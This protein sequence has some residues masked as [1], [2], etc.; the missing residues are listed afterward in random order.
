VPCLKMHLVEL[1]WVSGRWCTHIY[2]YIYT[3][4]YNAAVKLA[5]P[6]I[7]HLC[8]HLRHRPKDPA[9]QFSFLVVWARARACLGPG[10][11][12]LWSRPWPW[13]YGPGPGLWAHK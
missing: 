2:I 12:A 7:A 9:K 4:I 10:P 5:T 13:A 3:D 6:M 8:K 11:Q 1:P